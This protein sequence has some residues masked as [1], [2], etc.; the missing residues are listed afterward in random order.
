MPN[1]RPSD[2][3][4]YGALL[5]GS[6]LRRASEALYAGVDEIYE[7]QAV[8]FSS[9]CIPI[10][11]L[12]RDHGPL[13]ITELA[14]KLGLTHP[15]VIQMSRTL[16]DNG[17][18]I[19]RRDPQD[20]RRRVLTLSA[21]GRALLERLSIVWQA[22][23]SAVEDLSQAPEGN[24]LTTLSAFELGL[25]EKRFADRVSERLRVRERE[26]VRIIPFAPA[27][28]EDFKRLNLEW[29]ERYF[30]VEARDEDVLSRP[31][32]EILA[33]GGYIMLA[34]HHQEIVGTCAL[35]K[36]G[37]IRFELSKMA[38]TDR[39]Q[40]LG[41]GRK[42]LAAALAQFRK[43][44]ARHLYLETNTKLARAMALYRA[45]GFEEAPR[46]RSASAYRR[47]NVYM[48]YKVGSRR[49]PRIE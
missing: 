30:Y 25:Q 8:G 17:V 12:L 2:L 23:V 15:A 7:G 3:G 38:V 37:R 24:F 48:V 47:S 11:I 42:L 41:I 29:L 44:G 10:L 40:G 16:S 28:R 43:T 27:Y 35:I 31:E 22:V 36:A 13:G 4:D 39:Y 32:E 6:R 49:H 19:A 1:A 46:P 21:K 45:Y 34:R 20:E 5:L 18:L 9:R 33:P 14:A 26:S